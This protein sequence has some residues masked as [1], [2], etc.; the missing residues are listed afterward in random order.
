MSLVR[1]PRAARSPVGTLCLLACVAL[2]AGLLPWSAFGQSA[3]ASAPAAETPG[4]FLE[5]YV[6]GRNVLGIGW[7]HIHTVDSSKPVR[8]ST[9]SLHLGTYQSPGTE[10]MVS[11][12]DTLVLTFTHFFTDNIAATFAFG[13]PPKF[14]LTGRGNVIAPVP[15]VGPLT[16]V[17]L[18]APENNPLATVREWSPTLL[19]LYYFGDNDTKFRPFLG[20]GVNYTFFTDV[21]LKR[22]FEK[23]L[24]DLGPL[25]ELGMGKPPTGPAKVGVDVESSWQPVVTAGIQYEFAKNWFSIG[26]VSFL[27]LKSTATI[28][29]KNQ[30]SETLAVNKVDIEFNPVVFRLALGY[31]F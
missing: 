1:I 8:T 19:L 17:D 5:R 24:R 16:L 13:L 3:D 9:S 31:R 20:A 6:L 29:L 15:V 27:P 14:K 21:K 12:S 2:T 26:S 23:Q 30:A 25:L 10:T 11:D 28:T 7:A 18:G 4:G 22:N